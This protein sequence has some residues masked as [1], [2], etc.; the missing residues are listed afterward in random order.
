MLRKTAVALAISLVMPSA[1]WAVGLGTLKASSALNQPFAGKIE[2]LGA[3]A[4]DF[5]SL[6]V[7]L[8][9]AA[10]FERAGVAR[11]TVLLK[12]KFEII[13]NV[14]GVDYVR[15]SSTEAVREPYL[16]FLLEL[17][18][19]QGRMVREYTAL[20]DPP[21]YDTKRAQLRSA[22]IAAPAKPAVG[23]AR[24]RPVAA[25]TGEGAATASVQS[26]DT[27]WAL[28]MRYR[29]DSSISAQQM[30]LGLLRANP[31]GFPTGNVNVLR[32]GAVL[33]I[34]NVAE[35][36]VI[37]R[38]EAAAEIQRQTRV[39]QD[40]R[41]A[42]A[43]R[44]VPQAAA[45]AA[46]PAPDDLLSEPATAPQAAAPKDARLEVV[47][48]ANA[49]QPATPPRVG[50]VPSPPADGTSDMLAQEM[51]TTQTNESDEL[52]AKLTEAEGI[53]DLLQRQVQIKDEELA[54][55]QVNLGGGGDLATKPSDAP[56]ASATP[57]PNT[58]TPAPAAS[59]TPEPDASAAPTP[60]A[61]AIP[62]ADANAIPAPEASATPEPEAS[63]I[64]AAD[65]NA[66]PAP[67]ASATP[68]PTATPTPEVTTAVPVAVAPDSETALDA[69][70]PAS[71]RNLVP[72]GALT[73]IGILGSLLA[74]GVAALM[75]ALSG[76]RVLGDRPAAGIAKT[77]VVEQA[78]AVGHLDEFNESLLETSPGDAS[79]DPFSRTLEAS[80]EQLL[81]DTSLDPLE[82]VNVYLAY[83]RFDQAEALVREVIQQHPNEPKYKL[84]LLE[85]YYSANQPEAYENAAKDLHLAVG[86]NSA[87][88]GSA[89][90]MW[91]EMSPTHALL[92]PH[93]APA[94]GDGAGQVGTSVEFVDLTALSETP[95]HVPPNADVDTDL[96]FDLSD[97]SADSVLGDVLDSTNDQTDERHF[98]DLTA[99]VE[100]LE[101]A[102]FLPE[103]TPA[104][105]PE[106]DMFDVS[107]DS[108]ASAPSE[109]SL[110]F[111][112][113]N[114]GLLDL[115]ATGDLFE[116]HTSR[117]RAGSV[118]GLSATASG[119][120]FGGENTGHDFLSL[121]F[122]IGEPSLRLEDSLAVTDGGLDFDL[123]ALAGHEGE[124]LDFDL[125]GLEP[126]PLT[127]ATV[128]AHTTLDIAGAPE[129]EFSFD[130]EL[131]DGNSYNFDDL[132][133]ALAAEAAAEQDLLLKNPLF[134]L[135]TTANQGGDADE[136]E[137][138]F[139]LALQDTSDF[140]GILVDETLEMPASAAKRFGQTPAES[141]EDLTRSMEASLEG[142]DFEQD[143]ATDGDEFALDLS[144]A[145]EALGDDALDLDFDLDLAASDDTGKL[146]TE[147]DM[148]LERTG[149]HFDRS[150]LLP[151]SADDNLLHSAAEE[152]ENKLNLAK[153]YIELGEHAAAR[154]MLE[155]VE[156]E[157][158]SSQQE[159][160]RRLLGQ[161]R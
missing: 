118:A 124:T 55:L 71:W 111:T 1:V 86:E 88:W 38:A 152:A 35:L 155:E 114:I 132:A 158:S 23:Q 89:V 56:A 136:A 84:R 150:S 149:M 50:N 68:A 29:P 45:P 7:K 96:D 161:I 129:D 99:T 12:L 131:D 10:Q 49:G 53:I 153:A 106:H 51:A 156:K 47:T 15:V 66:I 11:S 48:P 109:P 26:H 18:W 3:T 28:A 116:E 139:D 93:A 143:D 94:A 80:S 137:L 82:E 108:I 134:D 36:N 117:P 81:A 107:G 9:D 6:N 142:F 120:G 46:L 76:R 21:L 52:K 2:I 57:V 5:E 138:E 121:E 157:G 4:A 22:P 110:E 14:G 13:V 95:Q 113:D 27:L 103:P 148:A 79:F 151:T 83:E 154:T 31:D 34:P 90:A 146:S 126:I 72:G 92:A 17:T 100:K 85:I 125:G 119:D 41:Q 75:R 32:Q 39:W 59:A 101:Q 105:E 61:S 97:L 37:S 87:L 30:M 133:P 42:A 16:D 69:L 65:A 70:V 160:A 25:V 135:H 64:P 78:P 127:E 67:E 74:L 8:A 33:R 104:N 44:P 54:R 19:A 144:A 58:T 60:E 140:S 102:G 40:Y 63:A 145:A 115:S 77:P 141:L 91:N 20:L 130:L 128:S 112:T 159:A 43:A 73:I 147:P 62:A 98:L 122:D 24:A 123:D